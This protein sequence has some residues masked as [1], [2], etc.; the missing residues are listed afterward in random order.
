MQQSQV[1]TP[2]VGKVD[3]F[4]PSTEPTIKRTLREVAKI[5]HHEWWMLGITHP[6]LEIVAPNLGGRNIF[7]WKGHLCMYEMGSERVTIL[8]ERKDGRG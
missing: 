6:D 1:A 2:T 5:R 8:C 7:T 4:A 3:W